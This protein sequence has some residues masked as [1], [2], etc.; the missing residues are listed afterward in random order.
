MV[1][2]RQG[3]YPSLLVR[4]PSLSDSKGR[5]KSLLGQRQGEVFV[6]PPGTLEK[7]K[8]IPSIHF[9]SSVSRV[10]VK[11]LSPATEESNRG[12]VPSLP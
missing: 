12:G 11:K 10:T 4:I 2:G 7:E 6:A 9:L 3:S 5:R 1:R 8:L